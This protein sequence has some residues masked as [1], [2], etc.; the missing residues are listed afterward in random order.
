MQSFTRNLLLVFINNTSD[1]NFF[2]CFGGVK[3]LLS[4]EWVRLMFDKWREILLGSFRKQKQKRDFFSLVQFKSNKRGRLVL[5]VDV[6]RRR[7][8]SLSWRNL[9][10]CRVL[11]AHVRRSLFRVL[12]VMSMRWSWKVELKVFHIHPTR[13][14]SRNAATQQRNEVCTR[15]IKKSFFLRLSIT[16]ITIKISNHARVVFDRISFIYISF[17]A[18]ESLSLSWQ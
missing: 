2:C 1:D 15:A 10:S 3:A 11:L 14:L 7:N 9:M 8:E 5:D 18:I 16:Q 12:Y 6:I 13:T 4:G 17:G